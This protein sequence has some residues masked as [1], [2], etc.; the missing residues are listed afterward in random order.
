V[1]SERPAWS[2]NGDRIVFA[3]SNA[4]GGSELWVMNADGSGKRRLTGSPDRDTEPSWIDD[5]IVFTRR[6]AL[7]TSDLYWM[8]VNG[9]L[10]QRLTVNGGAQMPAWSPDGRWIAFVVRDGES[11]LGDLLV[12]RPDGSDVRPL[13]LRADGPTGGGLN[14]AWTLHW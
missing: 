9:A 6:T 5:R 7:G 11:G 12:M 8:Y 1:S 3:A 4:R 13:S 14:P 10:A 2:P